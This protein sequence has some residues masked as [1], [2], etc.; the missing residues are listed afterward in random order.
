VSL[1]IVM[2]AEAETEF[3]EAFDYY[4][5]AR[6][7]RGVRFANLVRRVF[8]R[9]AARPQ[10]HRVVMANVRRAVVPKFPYC[11]YYRADA[12]RVEVLAVF[13]TSRDPSVWQG[14]V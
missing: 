1:L 6:P 2:R 9:I 5:N 7:G 11:V 12:A 3:D 4:E 14:R 13:H 10:A 8:R